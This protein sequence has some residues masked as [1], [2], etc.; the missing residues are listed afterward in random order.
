MALAE[1]LVGVLMDGVNGDLVGVNRLA[2]TNIY[3]CANL[4]IVYPDN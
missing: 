1:V 4:Y 3:S 2:E